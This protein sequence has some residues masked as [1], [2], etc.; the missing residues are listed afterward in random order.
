MCVG[1]KTGVAGTVYS[2]YVNTWCALQYWDGYHLWI[3]ILSHNGDMQIS[4]SV[5]NTDHVDVLV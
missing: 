2:T 5:T 4:E 3:L 1:S